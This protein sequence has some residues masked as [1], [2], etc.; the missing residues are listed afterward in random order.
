M[1]LMYPDY[2]KK[3]TDN[4]VLEDGLAITAYTLLDINRDS[5]L[6][7]YLEGHEI[8]S[9]D[10]DLETFKQAHPT[11]WKKFVSRADS[12][13]VYIFECVLLQNHIT[14]LMSLERSFK[15]CHRLYITCHLILWS[16]RFVMSQNREDQNIK[17]DRMCGLIE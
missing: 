5:E 8:Y 14:Q 12:N 1:L 11:R 13:T 7:Q 17:R 6:Y 9:I 16:R 3:L 15:R 2:E 10:A 4:T